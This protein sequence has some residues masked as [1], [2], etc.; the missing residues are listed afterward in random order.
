MTP[1]RPWVAA[2]VAAVLAG[3]PCA[4][5]ALDAYPSKPIRFILPQPAGGAV[6]LL[7]RTL[8]E[9]LTEQMKQPVIVENM[10]GANGSLAASAVAR[11]NPDGYTLFFAVDSNLVIN[12]H[13][14]KRLNYDPFRDFTPISI[15]AKLHMLLVANPK[16]EAN[17]LGELIAHANAHPGKLNYASIGYGTSSHMG[18]ELLKMMTKTDITLVP[19]RGTAPAMT[20]IVSGVVDVMFTGPPSGLALSQAGKVKVLAVSSPVRSP[21]MPDVP[22]LNEAGVPGFQIASWFGVLTPAQTPKDVVERLSREV[23]QAVH[24]SRF[25]DRMKAQ[26][27]EIVGNTSDEMLEVM[28]TETKHWAEVIRATGTKIPQ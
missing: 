21:L 10:P 26:G 15:V 23:S 8:G 6:D 20:D 25:G 16:V 12:P 18:M 11:S 22:T 4:V 24:D 3:L 14:Y 13:L 9:R 28:K 19:Y 1:R 27:V 2:A 7:A 5:Q 17:T